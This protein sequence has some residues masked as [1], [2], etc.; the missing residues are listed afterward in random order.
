MCGIAGAIN[1][2]SEQET[3]PENKL[4]KMGDALQHRGPDSENYFHDNG[5]S[6]V[7][8]RLSIIDLNGGNQPIFNENKSVCVILNG[9][10][11]NYRELRIQLERQGHSFST[12]TDTEVLVHLY[13]QHGPDFLPLLNGMFAFAL[14]DIEQQTLL[15][16]RDRFGVKPLFYT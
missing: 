6:F 1:L 9:E 14:Y 3:F 4:K 5:I 16:A 12:Q 10:I 15:L 2:S 11:Y 13:E 8:R 7:H